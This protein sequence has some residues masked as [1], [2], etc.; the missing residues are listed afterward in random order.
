[1]NP[2]FRRVFPSARLLQSH[3]EARA[4]FSSTL[5][6]FLVPWFGSKR[7]RILR[8]E[9]KQQQRYGDTWRYCIFFVQLQGFASDAQVGSR[10]H[11]HQQVTAVF[12][13]FWELPWLWV[14]PLK[15]LKTSGFS[16]K[17]VRFFV[18]NPALPILFL[19]DPK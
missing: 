14:D 16:V 15:P 18:E 6:L 5:W 8:R 2:I 17:N 7:I 11:L 9:C 12:V 19:C 3:R 1:M 4:D 13:H 10:F